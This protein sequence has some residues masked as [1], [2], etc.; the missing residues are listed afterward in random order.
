MGGAQRRPTM[1]TRQPRQVAQKGSDARRDRSER[2]GVAELRRT[3]ERRSNDADGLFASCLLLKLKHVLLRRSMA[4]AGAPADAAPSADPR[5]PGRGG[6]HSGRRARRA[7]RCRRCFRSAP[8]ACR[9]A[10]DAA[11]PSG[12]VRSRLGDLRARGDR[13]QGQRPRHA[14][15]RSRVNFLVTYGA[16]AP[17]AA[18]RARDRRRAQGTP[19]SVRAPLAGHDELL[20]RRRARHLGL[21]KTVDHDHASADVGDERACRLESTAR[22][23]L[24]L[25][26]RRG[27][28]RTLAEIPQDA[29]AWRDGTLFKTPVPHERRRGRV[30][31][32]RRHASA[33]GT[34]PMA[35]E[36]RTLGFPRRALSDDLVRTLAGDVRRR[37]DPRE[38]RR[39]MMLDIDLSD[40]DAFVDGIPHAAFQRLRVEAPVYWQPEKV[41]R[42]FWR[43]HALRRPDGGLE[44]PADVLLGARRYQHLRGARGGHVDAAAPHAQHGPA[45]AQQVPPASCRPGSP[46]AW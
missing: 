5:R 39:R 46:R 2:G 6:A 10:A 16:T 14:T 21:S 35:D 27:G 44:G 43:S 12:R 13:V 24:T 42:G 3:S 9:V 38:E 23:A 22:H 28:T 25:G 7:R 33:L 19:R 26:A 29:Y 15:T 31:A 41:G 1:R 11:A 36:L 30:P 34:H 18:R 4:A 32:R 40:P 37:P 45:E 17:V 20:A 8:S